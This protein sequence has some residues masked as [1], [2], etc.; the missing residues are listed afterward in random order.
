[1]KAVLSILVQSYLQRF[2]HGRVHIILMS[3]KTQN[4]FGFC[5]P[6]FHLSNELSNLSGH[7]QLSCGF[8]IFLFM[9][10]PALQHS[11]SSLRKWQHLHYKIILTLKNHLFCPGWC[12]SVGWTLFCKAKGCR[13]VRPPAWV[14]GLV[15]CQGTFERQLMMFLTLMFLS[16]SLPSP[17]SK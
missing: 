1:M 10:F 17:L 4:R 14:A 2:S 9:F 5:L 8:F 3:Q 7:L 16:F 15:P 11:K 13:I 6:D 12:G